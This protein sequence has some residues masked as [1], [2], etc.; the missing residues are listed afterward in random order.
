MVVS[1]ARDPRE[2]ATQLLR[3][4]PRPASAAARLGTRFHSWVERHYG[5][6]QLTERLIEDEELIADDE[7]LAQLCQSFLAS[8]WA[9]K[10]PLAVEVPINFDLDGL[11]VR[12]QIDAVFAAEDPEHDVLL[13]DWKTSEHGADPMQLALYRHAWSTATGVD[14]ARVD[15]CFVRIGSGRVERPRR[16][17]STEELIVGLREGLAAVGQG[18]TLTT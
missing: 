15:A 2:F 16:L 10:V 1:A 13:V 3:P 4:M 14:P 7:K 17:L 5:L 9:Q 12:G 18:T 11:E 8:P 6:A